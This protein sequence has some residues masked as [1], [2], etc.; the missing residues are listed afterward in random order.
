MPAV[1]AGAGRMQA[2]RSAKI[3]HQR[4]IASR[5]GRVVDMQ[6][7]GTERPWIVA[8]TRLRRR[9][10]LKTVHPQKSKEHQNRYV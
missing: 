2:L 8:D 7:F 6:E 9:A 5:S 4:Q 10:A 1:L 3:L